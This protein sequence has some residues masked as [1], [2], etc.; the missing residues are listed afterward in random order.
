[1]QTICALLVLSLFY[2][3]SAARI[4]KRTT[5]CPEKYANYTVTHTMC[6]TDHA[7]AVEVDLTQAEK[8]TIVYMHNSARRNVTS[9]SNMMKVKWD[10]RLAEVA[11]KWT[12]QCQGGH[13]ANRKEPDL[14]GFVGQNAAWSSDTSAG[15]VATAF[16]MWYDEIADFVYGNWTSE[17]GHYIQVIFAKTRLIGCGQAT[18]GSS[19]KFFACNYY[20]GTIGT[21]YVSGSRCNNCGSACSNNLCDCTTGPDA[22][23]NGGTFNINSCSCDCPSLWNG[24]AS[25]NTKS[26]PPSNPANYC[27]FIPAEQVSLYCG[28]SNIQEDCPYLCGQCP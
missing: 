21:P 23:F 22:C 9:A 17:T 26:C 10:D 27:G 11:Q 15:F 3:A 24:D 8:D 1:M 6:L 28:Y 14:P 18:C 13:D 19:G 4:V 12:M 20:S 25:C 16:R 7:N 5:S 2:A